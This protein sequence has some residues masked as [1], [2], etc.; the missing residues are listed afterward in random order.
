MASQSRADL[1]K[2]PV[3][4]GVAVGVEDDGAT[5]SPCRM[6]S[7]IMRPVRASRSRAVPSAQPMAIVRPSG[8]KA[9]RF[10]GLASGKDVPAERLVDV[11]QTWA[12]KSLPAVTSSFPSGRK[13]AW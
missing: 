10:T 6:G 2:L 4:D 12:S 9:A 5:L 11:S 1:S 13:A 3:S 8:L 7:P